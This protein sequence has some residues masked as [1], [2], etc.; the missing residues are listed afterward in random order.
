MMVD[1]DWNRLQNIVWCALGAPK[2][3]CMLCSSRSNREC[4][5]CNSYTPLDQQRIWVRIVRLIPSSGYGVLA[6]STG[7]ECS[8]A[9]PLIRELCS[10]DCH[11]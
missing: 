5:Y 7:N 9:K 8:M 10:L 3:Y 6:I 4:T 2:V 1:L 11:R